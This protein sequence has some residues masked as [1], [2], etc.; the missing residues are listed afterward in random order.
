MSKLKLV[1][2]DVLVE[3]ALWFE[4]R[5][6]AISRESKGITKKPLLCNKGT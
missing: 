2:F 6:L 1:P 5:L 3:N 4:Q